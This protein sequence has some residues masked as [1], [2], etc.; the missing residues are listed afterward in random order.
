MKEGMKEK[1]NISYKKQINNVLGRFS[2]DNKDRVYLIN[3]YRSFS[4]DTFEECKAVESDGTFTYDVC[5][6]AILI[7]VIYG[8]VSQVDLFV[9]QCKFIKC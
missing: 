7:T 3:A 1:T 9:G 4:R 6:G 2:E 5:V 8:N